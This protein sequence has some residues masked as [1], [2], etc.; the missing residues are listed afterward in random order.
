MWFSL[1]FLCFGV[2]FV[3]NSQQW[4]HQAPASMQTDSRSVLSSRIFRPEGILEM[5][6]HICLGLLTLFLPQ[7]LVL[8]LF[9]FRGKGWG[10]CQRTTKAELLSLLRR[11]GQI[12]LGIRA[13]LVKF[14]GVLVQ[15]LLAPSAGPSLSTWCHVSVISFAIGFVL[16][17]KFQGISGEPCAF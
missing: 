15:K 1:G 3:L 13:G 14:S 8:S 17:L 2:F 12:S 9:P 7:T 10:W 6:V 5:I 16:S 11:Y 4:G